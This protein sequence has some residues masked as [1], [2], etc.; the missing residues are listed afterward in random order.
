MLLDLPIV[1]LMLGAEYGIDF[2][3]L[4]KDIKFNPIISYTTRP[5]RESE[6]EGVE[7][8]FISNEDADTILS[9]NNALAFT[10]INNNRC[11]TL[12]D[13][14]KNHN[15]YII[16][17]AGIEDLNNKYPDIKKYIIYVA[18]EYTNR[19]NRYISRS[20]ECS[21]EDFEKRN[22]S[23]NEQFSRFETNM[24]DY[25]NTHILSNNNPYFV[26]TILNAAKMIIDSYTDD[27]LYCIVGRTAAGK[28]I[29]TRNLT[30]LFEKG[31]K[32]E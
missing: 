9:N 21:S 22:L 25:P 31:N 14:L 2:D 18:A 8:Y 4:T 28:D 23:E 3:T 32:E 29:I 5:K 11:F 16:D 6:V 24:R 17:P 1:K 12:C 19:L 20:S 7:H 26:S 15:V 13:Q 10:I 30:K 27:T